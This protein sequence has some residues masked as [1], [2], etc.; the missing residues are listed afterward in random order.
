MG[1]L[2]RN[3]DDFVVWERNGERI[4]EAGE[5]NWRAFM[6]KLYAERRSERSREVFGIKYYK[7]K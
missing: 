3:L 6:L 2:L 5:R 4:D 1:A 7:V